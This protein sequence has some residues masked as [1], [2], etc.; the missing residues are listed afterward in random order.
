MVHAS[1]GVRERRD[2]RRA[3]PL[4]FLNVFA[5]CRCLSLNLPSLTLFFFQVGHAAMLKSKAK[6]Q[7]DE[8]DFVFEDTIDF[9]SQEVL[10]QKLT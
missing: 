7:E 5:R 6:K 1:L 3:T 8:Y 2:G 4:S 10:Q 9:V